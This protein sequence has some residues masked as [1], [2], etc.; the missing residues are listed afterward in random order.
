MG[1]PLIEGAM[2]GALRWGAGTARPDGRSKD[3]GVGD[4]RPVPHTAEHA[5]GP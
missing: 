5:G 1:G 4:A 3:R 2:L